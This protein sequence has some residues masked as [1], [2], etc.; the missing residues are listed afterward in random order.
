MLLVVRQTGNKADNYLWNVVRIAWTV[1]AIAA[2]CMLVKFWSD[3]ELIS[4]SEL[5]GENPN[6]TLIVLYRGQSVSTWVSFSINTWP[7]LSLQCTHHRSERGMIGFSYLPLS[8]KRLWALI[9]NLV[10]LFLA[11]AYL[12]KQRYFS[13]LNSC[14]MLL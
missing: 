11:S 1:L 7:V 10:R 2:A 4:S 13:R 9:R 3:R 12:T 6:L 8:M 14:L 5:F